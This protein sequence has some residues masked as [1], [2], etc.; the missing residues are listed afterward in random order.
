MEDDLKIL[1]TLIDSYSNLNLSLY[2][3]T[4]FCQSFK[5]RQ[6]PMEDDLKTSKVEYLINCYW[7]IL[8][9]QTLAFMTKPYFVNP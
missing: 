3:Q 6:P 9:F 7:I 2:D 8:K 5:W 1:L 4:I